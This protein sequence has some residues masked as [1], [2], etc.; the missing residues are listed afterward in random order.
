MLFNYPSF[1]N[2][3]EQDES[4]IL[5]NNIRL[6]L[7]TTLKEL[8]YNLDFGTNIRNLIKNGIN[9]MIVAEIQLDIE[10]NLIQY[11]NDDIKLNYLDIEQDE[12]KIKISLNYTELRTGKHNTVQAEETFINNNTIL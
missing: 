8:W 3:A 11:F 6:V 7:Q 10:N 1:I 2:T 12:S 4:R 5:F 9:S